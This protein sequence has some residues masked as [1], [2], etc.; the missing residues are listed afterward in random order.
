MLNFCYIILLLLFGYVLY[1]YIPKQQQHHNTEATTT[2]EVRCVQFIES[3]LTMSV[4]S[5]YF[6]DFLLLTLCYIAV[7]L[8]FVYVLNQFLPKQQQHYNI[9]QRKLHRLRFVCYWDF[10]FKT[11]YVSV[12]LF[13]YFITYHLLQFSMSNFCD[14]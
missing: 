6:S 14:A 7:L 13:L 12:K 2:A 1:E 3:T 9:K 5:L 8:L 11:C 4:T 10:I